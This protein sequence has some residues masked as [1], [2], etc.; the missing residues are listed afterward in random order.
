YVALPAQLEIAFGDDET[1]L[2]GFDRFE[3]RSCGFAER[4]LVEQE[5]GGTLGATTNAAAQLVQLGEAEAL[6]MLDDHDG[7]VGDIDPNLD[8]SCGHQELDFIS[9]KAGHDLLLGGGG[10][11]AMH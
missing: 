9:L 1:V 11:A 5:A 2:G 10:H 8:D 7:G 4:V 6:G 3:T